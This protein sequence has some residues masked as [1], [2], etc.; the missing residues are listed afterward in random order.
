MRFLSVLR[1]GTLW[2]TLIVRIT[3]F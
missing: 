2:S 3:G 1:P